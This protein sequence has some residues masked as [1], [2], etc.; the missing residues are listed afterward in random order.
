LEDASD[1]TDYATHT[2]YPGDESYSEQDAEG[3]IEKVR[4]IYEF[5]LP[6]IEALEGILK[7]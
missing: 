6:R 5:T 7:E 3:A 2:R 1:L 4:L